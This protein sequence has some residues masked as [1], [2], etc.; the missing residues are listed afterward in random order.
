MIPQVRE[1]LA[2]V[3]PAARTAEELLRRMAAAA[4]GAGLVGEGFADAVV[5]REAG[6]PTGLPTPVPAAIPH[7]DAE[8]VRE[9]GLVVALLAEPVGFT[10]MATT[11]RT[12]PARLVV[13]LLVA[14]PE[15]QVQTLTSVIGLLQDPGLARRLA[16]VRTPAELVRAVSTTVPA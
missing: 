14:D 4:H 6:F 12:V 2:L 13:M 11:D 8:H 7:T 15:A 5:A 10:E 1:D 16:G 3:A 9:P